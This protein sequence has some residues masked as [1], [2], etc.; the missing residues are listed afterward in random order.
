[1]SR[2]LPPPGELLRQAPALEVLR[3]WAGPGLTPACSI[4][5]L[6]KDVG[7]WGALLAVAARQ[8]ASAYAGAGTTPEQAF[9][10]LRSALLEALAREPASAPATAAVAPTS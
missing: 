3:V 6:W 10:R 4:R 5:P 7:A 2:D 9:A 8:V 1:M